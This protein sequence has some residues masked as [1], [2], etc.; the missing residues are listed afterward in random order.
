MCHVCSCICYPSLQK[1]SHVCI[2]RGL[3]RSRIVRFGSCC[4]N[5]PESSQQRLSSCQSVFHSS[6]IGQ[7]GCRAHQYQT[8]LLWSKS[9]HIYCLHYR[10]DGNAVD[11]MFVKLQLQWSVATVGLLH[12]VYFQTFHLYPCNANFQKCDFAIIDW[13]GKF[14]LH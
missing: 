7:Y 11:K 9:L 8:Q 5:N 6:H 14:L 13:L 1:L 2:Y 10:Y 3:F 4:W 12:H